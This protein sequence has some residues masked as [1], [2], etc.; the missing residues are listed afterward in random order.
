M[1]PPQRKGQTILHIWP[2]SRD[3]SN[4]IIICCWFKKNR[5]QFF[6][7][8]YR[9]NYME[10]SHRNF[11]IQ[12]ANTKIAMSHI[13]LLIS[14][15]VDIAYLAFCKITAISRQ[16]KLYIARALSQWITSH[17]RTEWAFGVGQIIW[18]THIIFPIPVTFYL[19]WNLLEDVSQQTQ[20]ADTMLDW[21]RPSV[22]TMGR[23]QS[24]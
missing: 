12:N 18:S 16:K 14:E 9:H 3:V 11:Q 2:R 23:H 10:C 15:W 4:M 5:T 7:S 1:C 20:D 8:Q 13:E 22:K 19:N 17:N 6:I 21:C 24:R